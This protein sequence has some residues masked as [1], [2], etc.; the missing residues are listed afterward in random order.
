M[1]KDYYRLTKPGIVYGNALTAAA[2]YFVGVHGAM[3]LAVFA[4]MLSG[5]SLIIASG[6]VFN[7]VIDRDIDAVMERTKNRALVKGRISVPSALLFGSVLG[8]LGTICLA[9]TTVTAVTVALSGLFAYTVIYSLWCKRNT[10]H[11]TI[12]GSVSG[13]VPPVV[14]YAAVVGS[15]DLAAL[16]LFLILF[17]WQMPHAL[18][19]AIRRIDDYR[20]A[21]I[22]VMPV[23]LNPFA[24]KL[25]AFTYAAVF[26]VASV[27]LG[28]AGY[29]GGFYTVSM[30]ILGIVWLIL[31]AQGFRTSDDRKWA[32]RV[33]LFSLILLLAFCALTAFD[34][35]LG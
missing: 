34:A 7:N 32:K 18:A 6:C 35:L 15:L 13:S 29:A 1:I 10:L 14:G 11:A 16:I 8:I 33:F 21:G 17:A 20:A 26:V 5:I 22:P 2:G 19:I 23:A 24:A 25:Q 28:I 4:W 9:F 3:D 31:C 12:I 27:S 30:A